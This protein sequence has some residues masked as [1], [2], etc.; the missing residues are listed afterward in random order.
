MSGHDPT[1]KNK[2]SPHIQHQLPEFVKADHPV[3][4]LFLQ[5]YYEFLEA[6]ELTL[7]GSND[8]VLDETLS[9]NYIL[10]EQ[11]ENIVLEESVGKFIAGETL[12][13]QRSN[14]TAKV[15]VD[16]FDNNNRLFITSQQRFETGE[17]VIGQT[18][19]A[20][21]TVASYR[22]NP[23][24]NIQQLLA[25]ADVDN[26]IYDFL[27]NF[28]DSFMEA[29]PNTVADGL[30]KRK[31]I[32]SIKELYSAKGTEDG[33]KMFFRILF[34][35]E[36]TILYPRDNLLRPSDGIWSTEK[37]IRIV[38][39]DNSDFGQSVGQ[40][41]TGQTSG[42]T[43]L[44]VSIIRFRE[45]ATLVAELSL[46]ADSIQGTFLKD[47]TV[48]SINSEL[49]LEV[50]GQVKQI[51]N[52]AV[53]DEGGSYYQNNDIIDVSGGNGNDEATAKIESIGTGSI[54]EIII[55]NGG[56][57]Y[58]EGQTVTFDLGNTEGVGLSARVAV[59]GGAF[60]LEQ[61][62]SPDH[63]ISEDR[64][65]L[66]FEDSDYIK[67][68]ETVG[69]LDHLVLEDG[70]QIVL[71]EE[72]FN[73][74]GVSSEIGEITKI[75]IINPGNGF[76]KLPLVSVSTAF[77]GS[78][79]ELYAIST[80]AP[81]VGHVA[82][83]VITN[84]GLDYQNAPTLTLNKILIVRNVS[85]AFVRGDT[86]TSH[87]A[88]VVNFD[89]D[90]NL[91]EL[92]SSVTFNNGD[93]IQLVTG[94]TCEVYQ[95]DYAE[96]TATI[97]T[98]GTT[99]AGI[100]L[101]NDRGK[102]SVDTMKLQDSFYYQDYSYV[103]RIGQSINEWRESVRRS[104][105]PAGW[106]VFGEVSFATQVSAAIQSPAAGSVRDNVS[107]DTF[108]PELAST[109]T[110]LFTVIFGRRLGTKTDG[111]EL[112]GRTDHILLED[113]NIVLL[114]DGSKLIYNEDA[115]NL[116]SSEPLST[117]VREVTLTSAVHV[118][119]KTGRG[120]HWT[121]WGNLANLPRYAFASLPLLTDE[122]ASN[123]HDPA[124]RRITA[125]TNITS[126]L[127]SIAQFG[128]IG[129]RQVCL[130]DGTIPAS[131]FTTRTNV[132]PPSEIHF[133]RGGLI[134]SF[135]NDFISFDDNIQ[136]FDE[137]GTPR[138]T[139]GRYAQ[140]FDGILRFDNTTNT[141][142]AASGN[143]QDF[144]PTFDN[145]VTTIDATELGGFD[146]ALPGTRNVNLFSEQD[147]DTFDSVTNTTFDESESGITRLGFSVID[148]YFDNDTR[149]FDKGT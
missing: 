85:G 47:E 86:L 107:K 50:F 73:D 125:P 3:F 2:V 112:R 33:H 145:D 74:L 97:G 115:S 23:V 13:G 136:S 11:G 98:I 120:S 83:A 31:L 60:V 41:V 25:Y 72:T 146:T 89:V 65:L 94:S 16:D 128:H 53:V 84:Y 35:E 9:K 130:A 141:Y 63:F 75:E 48:T 79:A 131:A 52:D 43:A 8:Y 147:N 27:D 78:G 80:V 139:E 140:S 142:D 119:M 118:Q 22:G 28:R 108:S 7:T 76:V 91:L 135:D 90:R 124:G 40:V 58:I 105:H 70:S 111:T 95:A 81:R 68:E 37:L 44:L 66:I 148:Q 77:G 12:V 56:S 39:T 104:V 46:D 17:T 101:T 69:E 103:V 30:S 18:S 87:D 55:D 5:Y 134:Q 71:E 59:V 61:S 42:A 96:A 49:D 19:G 144:R 10:D 32:K 122:I 137:E 29:L 20:T 82:S 14:A 38:E 129:I 133:D 54:D 149:T 34:D 6:G 45:G 36:A 64:E 100:S 93:I 109:F 123:Y 110:N 106:N 1:L 117:G 24:Q 51:V 99:P 113:N 15:L 92:E 57:G 88:T 67:Q 127:Y 121:G 138:D 102:V 26:T 114:E 21:S 116:G 4:S 143:E 132:P 62:T 126:G